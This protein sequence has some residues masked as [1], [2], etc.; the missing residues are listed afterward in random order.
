MSSTN[1]NGTY[2]G[3]MCT[4]NVIVMLLAIDSRSFKVPRH[5]FSKSPNLNRLKT[6]LF[7]FNTIAS[8]QT[9]F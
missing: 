9:V 4:S 1:N 8:L 2:M 7:K 5:S 6:S 3:T